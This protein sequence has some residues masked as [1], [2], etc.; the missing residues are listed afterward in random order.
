MVTTKTARDAVAED[1]PMLPYNA[2]TQRTSAARYH[3]T[4]IISNKQRASATGFRG[5]T[6]GWVGWT[7][8]GPSPAEDHLLWPGVL[9]VGELAQVPH[10]PERRH[11][12]WLSPP[13]LTLRGK[14]GS[15][16]PRIRIQRQ[17]ALPGL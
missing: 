7:A 12:G 14:D 13:N 10:Y 8:T 16:Y 4:T 5:P 15:T 1:A 17:L 9:F 2:R 3:D 6:P 11:S